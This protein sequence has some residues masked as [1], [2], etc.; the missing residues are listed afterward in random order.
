MREID[1]VEELA[2]KLGVKINN[3]DLFL[4]AITHTS[5]AHEYNYNE[6]QHNERLEF[7]GDAVLELIIS[8]ILYFRYPNLPEGQL[9]KLRA[10][11]VCEQSLLKVAHSLNLGEYLRLGR[12]EEASGGRERPSILADAVEALLGALYLEKGYK[13]TKKVV[14]SCMKERLEKVDPRQSTVDFK[15]DLQE[16]TQRKYEICP[17]Y[18]IEQEIGPDH[19][20]EFIAVVKLEDKIWARGKG[21]SKKEA[22]QE[23]AKYA[24]Q[25][26]KKGKKH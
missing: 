18:N 10:T 7:L 1:R 9:T 11:I 20:K 4:Q 13:K 15:T 8:E 17:V 19:D 2:S 6:I 26:I 3:Y 24:W 16:L 12:G 5:Y 22:E 14:A 21:K 23:A 25:K